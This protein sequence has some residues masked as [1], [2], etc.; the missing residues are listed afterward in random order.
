MDP[1][2]S[3]CDGAGK[4][5]K[6]RPPNKD[7][8]FPQGVSRAGGGAASTVYRIQTSDALSDE[9]RGTE[10]RILFEPARA[11]VPHLSSFIFE[12]WARHCKCRRACAGVGKAFQ[13]SASRNETRLGRRVML[14]DVKLLCKRLGFDP[15]AR[16]LHAC[17]HSFGKNYVSGAAR[18]AT[19]RRCS[20]IQ[21]WR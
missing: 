16:T 6:I 8:A 21:P 5:S 14:R 20:G 19:C 10:G 2:L 11:G 15:P 12:S 7:D 17:R 1:R 3:R 18:S 4:H 13:N 9:A